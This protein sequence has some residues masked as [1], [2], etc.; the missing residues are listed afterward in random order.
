VLIWWAAYME[1]AALRRK[2][3]GTNT[4][5]KKTWVNPDYTGP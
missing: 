1:A 3:Q 5:G 4:D 2:A